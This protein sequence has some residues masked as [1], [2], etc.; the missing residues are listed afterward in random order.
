M[1]NPEVQREQQAPIDPGSGDSRLG[2][3]V[4]AALLMRRAQ[5]QRVWTGLR[6][7]TNNAQR[8]GSRHIALGLCVLLL[9]VLAIAVFGRTEISHSA[10]GAATGS[11]PNWDFCDHS[12]AQLMHLQAPQLSANNANFDRAQL[13]EANL[14]GA[15]LAY[16]RL[17]RANLSL[18]DLS[19]ARLVGADLSHAV[20]EHA[21]LN[22][23]DLRYANL[24]GA[25]VHGSSWH[26]TRLDYATWTDGR[27]CQAGSVGRC[28]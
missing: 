12:G 5:Q 25:R 19:R 24:F 15:D 27:E 11:K 6:T 20:I 23:A 22:D 4:S 17:V 21:R 10:C 28:R 8:Q 18:T 1:N 2:Q 9:G 13:G 26:N 16:S 3:R 14:A 7:D